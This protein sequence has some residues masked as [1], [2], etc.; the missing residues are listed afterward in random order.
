MPSATRAM[1]SN[2]NRRGDLIFM[3]A[4]SF[5]C[6]RLALLYPDARGNISH[7]DVIESA[8]APQVACRPAARL[9]NYIALR[10]KEQG[11]VLPVGADMIHPNLP[12]S[13]PRV[14]PISRRITP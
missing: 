1:P 11:R 3:T 12:P 10:Y 6:C 8:Q 13:Q 5:S 2:E 14:H 7:S 4:F 9:T